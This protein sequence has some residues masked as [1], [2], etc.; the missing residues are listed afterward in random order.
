[1]PRL[2]K[3]ASVAIAALVVAGAATG[4][5]LVSPPSPRDPGRSGSSAVVQAAPSGQVGV[6]AGMPSTSAAVLPAGRRPMVLFVGG[7]PSLQPRAGVAGSFACLAAVSLQWQ[8]EVRVRGRSGSGWPPAAD[9]VVVT[10]GPKDGQAVAARTL[11]AL[12]AGLRTGTV[13]LLGPVTASLSQRTV[14]QVAGLRQ[15]ALDRGAV[16]VNPVAERWVT[17]ATRAKFLSA[18]GVLTVAGQEHVA[19]RLAVALARVDLSGRAAG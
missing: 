11:D 2:A 7:S 18:D 16:F 13:V 4:A 8:C 6:P 10:V 14:A 5:A 9:L 12:P 15:L 19:V 1:M 3:S 17:A